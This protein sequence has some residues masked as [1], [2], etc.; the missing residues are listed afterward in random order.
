VITDF[1]GDPLRSFSDR[2]LKRSPLRDVAGMIRSIR[3][4]A[5]EGFLK[6]THVEKD[7][8]NSLLPFARLWAHYMVGFFMKAYLDTVKD[9]SFIPS[10]KQD[11]QMMVETYMLD[12]ALHDLKYELQNRPDWVIIP[13]RTIKSIIG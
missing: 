11:F 3:N 7:N 8:I 4:V 5:F 13:V 6:T 1:G 2:R 12:K 10:D 9:S